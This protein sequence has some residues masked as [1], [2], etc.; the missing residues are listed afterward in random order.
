[1]SITLNLLNTCKIGGLFLIL[2]KLRFSSTRINFNYKSYSNFILCSNVLKMPVSC[3]T[4][5]SYL[6]HKINYKIFTKIKNLFTLKRG[7][8]IKQF[9]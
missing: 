8:R 9:H 3:W 7:T 2:V 6:H 1:M 5:S 4:V